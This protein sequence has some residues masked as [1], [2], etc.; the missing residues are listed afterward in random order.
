MSGTGRW[1]G[2]IKH[3]KS[4]DSAERLPVSNPGSR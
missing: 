1:L 3:A 4:T 2:E